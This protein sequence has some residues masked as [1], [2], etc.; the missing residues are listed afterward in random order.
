MLDVT[1]S[2]RFRPRPIHTDR[3]RL[4]LRL[5]RA[6]RPCS[7]CGSVAVGGVLVNGS[8]CSRLYRYL[9]CRPMS[10]TVHGIHVQM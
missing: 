10:H 2:W 6:A 5:R 9:K 1:S 4:R 3:W 8:G 7:P